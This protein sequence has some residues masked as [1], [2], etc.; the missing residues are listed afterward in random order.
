VRIGILTARCANLR[1][2][3]HAGGRHDGDSAQPGDI[4]CAATDAAARGRNSATECATGLNAARL[5]GEV[6][7]PCWSGMVAR[8][9][10]P[11]QGLVTLTKNRSPSLAAL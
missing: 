9:R 7:V 11:D 4:D 8:K 5:R 3:R 6:S 10:A 1:P 2:H